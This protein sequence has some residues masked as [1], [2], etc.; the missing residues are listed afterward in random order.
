MYNVPDKVSLSEANG[1]NGIEQIVAEFSLLQTQVSTLIRC[2]SKFTVHK[3]LYLQAVTEQVRLNVASSC[4]PGYKFSNESQ[5]C[6]CMDDQREVLRCD[7]F[8]RYFYTQ[9]SGSNC[10]RL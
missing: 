9:V 4:H 6:V 3:Y 1:V 10:C 7:S 8:N 5:K 2:I